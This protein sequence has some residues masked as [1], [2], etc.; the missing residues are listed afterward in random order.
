MSFLTGELKKHEKEPFRTTGS[1]GLLVRSQ[2]NRLVVRLPDT[3]V[4]ERMCRL[5]Y[6]I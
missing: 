2:G 5:S 3:T 6:H 4:K 1:P